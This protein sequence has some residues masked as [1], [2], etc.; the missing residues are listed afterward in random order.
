MCTWVRVLGWHGLCPWPPIARWSVPLRAGRAWW[1]AQ[2]W[3]SAAHHI[4][5]RG[6]VG[7]FLGAL[8]ALSA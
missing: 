2:A 5:W 7:R 8:E 3:R 1:R 6:L 4:R